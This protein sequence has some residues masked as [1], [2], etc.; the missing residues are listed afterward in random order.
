MAEKVPKGWKK[1]GKFLVKNFKFK[2]FLEA[3]GFLNIV[4]TIAEELMHH[5]DLSLENYNELTIK[6]TTHE[7]GRLTEKDSELA[8]RINKILAKN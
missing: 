3:V 7:K 4:S 5:P 8:D 6:T 2:T 1:E